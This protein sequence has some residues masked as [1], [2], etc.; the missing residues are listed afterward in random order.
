MICVVC[1]TQGEYAFTKRNEYHT[2]Q[3]LNE[4]Q[5]AHSNKRSR[6]VHREQGLRLIREPHG[7]ESW[8]VHGPRG[9][10]LP[11]LRVPSGRALLASEQERRH[12][13]QWPRRWWRVRPICE[14]SK[15][16]YLC[17]YGTW[18]L[19]PNY[20]EFDK[21]S[22]RRRWLLAPTPE[23]DV[24][25]RNKDKDREDKLLLLRSTTWP[26][27]KRIRKQSVTIKND[28]CNDIVILY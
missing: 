20:R 24:G 17:S 27:L 3:S 18:R 7:S 26:P 16:G 14:R 19:R 15:T 8:P 25:T 9:T 23:T 12:G 28:V 2:R 10:V 5:S 1:T 11:T 6:P 4:L 21:Y 13:R 22:T